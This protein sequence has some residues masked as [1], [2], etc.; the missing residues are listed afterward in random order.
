[1]GLKPIP[2][3]VIKYAFLK[4]LIF[5]KEIAISILSLILSVFFKNPLL[6]L[7]TIHLVAKY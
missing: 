7:L 1:M 6:K 5:I 3:L 2:S 4:F